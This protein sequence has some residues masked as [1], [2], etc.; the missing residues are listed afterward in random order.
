MKKNLFHSIIVSVVLLARFVPAQAQNVDIG[1]NTPAYSAALDISSTDKGLLI[2]RL[3]AVQKLAITTPVNG[4]LIYQT[5]A[6]PCLYFYNGTGCT[7]ISNGSAF[8]ILSPINN[9]IIYRDMPGSYGY[10]AVNYA[11]LIPLLTKSIKGQ[12]QQINHLLLQMETLQKQL[13]QLTAAESIV[14]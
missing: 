7:N 4:L 8:F 3:T 9:N 1:T 2:P 12:Q 11:A 10:K 14:K 5:D 6:A 13:R